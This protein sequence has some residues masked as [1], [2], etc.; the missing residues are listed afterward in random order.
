MTDVLANRADNDD[1]ER[2]CS[3]CGSKY[4][5]VEHPLKPG[6]SLQV[7]CKCEP[8]SVWLGDNKFT[9]TLLPPR[10][11]P[12]TDED[13]HARARA[14][15]EA[16]RDHGDGTLVAFGYES[17]TAAIAQLVKERDELRAISS[18]W[19]DG[20]FS[21]KQDIDDCLKILTGDDWS[22]GR[23]DVLTDH[24]RIAVGEINKWKAIARMRQE[25]LDRQTFAGETDRMAYER[26]R[27]DDA[28]GTADHR[29]LVIADLTR[30][31]ATA[32]GVVEALIAPCQD[33]AD[34][35]EAREGAWKFLED[36][37]K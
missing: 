37:R 24:C 13:T 22:G 21:G 15:V 34:V 20:Y 25:R 2:V 1:G 28:K 30:K 17:L 18:N 36:S 29:A 33:G 31:L 26:S 10:K 5:N 7:V 35:A 6:V 16:V 19:E 4:V 8:V 14:I 12:W 32:R 3:Q 11:V 9:T 27:A 23:M